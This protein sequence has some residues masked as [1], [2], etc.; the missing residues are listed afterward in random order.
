M[1]FWKL[2]RSNKRGFTL[3]ELLIVGIILAVIAGLAIP[4]YAS[5]VE[6]GRQQEALRILSELRESV[7]R[8]NSVNAVAPTLATIDVKLPAAPAKVLFNYAVAAASVTATRTAVDFSAALSG[9]TA[10][11]VMSVAVDSGAVVDPC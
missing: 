10:G 8:W 3:M 4:G 9:C 2:L 7:A 5:S 6:Q 11:Y 1:R